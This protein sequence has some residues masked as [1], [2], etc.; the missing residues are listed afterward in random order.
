MID[1]AQIAS[2]Q[3]HAMPIE[4]FENLD[5]DFA[6]VVET[7]SECGGG[8][9]SVRRLGGK[10]GGNFRH[11]G[12]GAAKKEVILGHFINFAEA[13]KQLAQPAYLGL[14]AADHAA[15]VTHPRRAKAF[16][17]GEQWSYRSPQ[18]FLVGGQTRLVTRQPNPGAV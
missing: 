15:H 3:R 10:I 12:D 17:A 18:G 13:A 6:A 14:A 9:L 5:G 16:F 8:E 11:L 4:E 1:A 7:I 2:P